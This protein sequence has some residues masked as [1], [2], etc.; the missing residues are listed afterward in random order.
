M[1]A[2]KKLGEVGLTQVKE[3]HTN[4]SYMKKYLIL[5]L[6]ALG[7]CQEENEIVYSVDPALAPYVETFYAEVAERGEVIPKNL[8]AEFSQNI[9]GITKGDR[10]HG[11]NYL[12]VNEVMFGNLGEIQREAFIA[13]QLAGTFLGAVQPCIDKALNSPPRDCKYEIAKYDRESTFDLFVDNP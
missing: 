3:N 6:A 1:T 5:F 4:T 13:H 7:A 10:M 12:Y 8:I 11:Q 2:C 9:Q